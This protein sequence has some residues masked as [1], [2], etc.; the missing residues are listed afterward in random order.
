MPRAIDDSTEKTLYAS[1]ENNSHW[2][3]MEAIPKSK[4]FNSYDSLSTG[5]TDPK[6]A[7][8]RFVKCEAPSQENDYDCGIFSCLNIYYISKN[9]P[10]NKDT[11]SQADIPY[12][13]IMMPFGLLTQT[14]LPTAAS[15]G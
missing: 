7:D 1:N 4:V 9:K 2:I 15:P 12:F 8:Y 5:G 13:R 3:C 6:V 11:F 14:E 10:I